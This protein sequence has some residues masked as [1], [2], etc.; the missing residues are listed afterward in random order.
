MNKY[1]KMSEYLKELKRVHPNKNCPF[2]KYAINRW[3][4][5]PD[6]LVRKGG[7]VQDICTCN[8]EKGDE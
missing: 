3:Y 2:R 1:I 8:K 6:F 5:E 4:G 7:R